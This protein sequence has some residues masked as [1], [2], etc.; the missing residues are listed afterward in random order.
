MID[1]RRKLQNW[2]NLIKERMINSYFVK[3]LVPVKVYCNRD[4]VQP[5][6]FQK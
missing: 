4:V 1:M 3:G 5:P 2:L 6:F